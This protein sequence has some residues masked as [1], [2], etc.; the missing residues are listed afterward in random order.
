MIFTAWYILLICFLF[1]LIIPFPM[2]SM[3]FS[4]TFHQASNYEVRTDY[5]YSPVQKESLLPPIIRCFPAKEVSAL[6]FSTEQF[7][8]RWDLDGLLLTLGISMLHIWQFKCQISSWNFV[9]V[10]FEH[11]LSVSPETVS[12]PPCPSWLQWTIW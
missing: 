9:F 4:Y 6:L 1:C 3:H 8:S 11:R 10:T 2:S 5:Y 7:W 12:I